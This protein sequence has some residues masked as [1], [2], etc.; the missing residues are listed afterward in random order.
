MTEPTIS[1]V[2]VSHERDDYLHL[3]A[4]SLLQQQTSGTYEFVLFRNGG[5]PVPE[6][7]VSLLSEGL[8]NWFRLFYSPLNLNYGAALIKAL[9]S[10]DAD[11]ILV[12][13]DDDLLL[14]NYLRVMRGLATEN[15]QATLLSVGAEVIDAQGNEQ[16]ITHSPP[17]FTSQLEAISDLMSSSVYWMPAS[18]FRRN[19]VDLS[20][21]PQTR[22]AID[23]WIWV[24]CWLDGLAEVSPEICVQYRRHSNQESHRYP[25]SV[26][27]ADA[28]EMLTR[29]IMSEKYRTFLTNLPTGDRVR[30]ADR[31]QSNG[32]LGGPDN[33]WGPAIAMTL[34]S[35]L[36]SLDCDSTAEALLFNAR[37]KA[38]AVPRLE[39]ALPR[40]GALPLA[41]IPAGWWSEVGIGATWESECSFAADWRRALNLP[42]GYDTIRV[43]LLV[44]C[45]CAGYGD[46]SH[47]LEFFRERSY[48]RKHPIY[49]LSGAV[50]SANIELFLDSL[51]PLADEYGSPLPQ[52]LFERQILTMIRRMKRSLIGRK[53]IEARRGLT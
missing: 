6:Q 3:F 33:G 11:Y 34:G 43:L 13:G 20:Q 46:G 16:G 10:V 37:A 45:S 1:V 23:W 32:A 26:F 7:T 4:K 19:S 8:G 48:R 22:T 27:H 14:P 36:A 44:R 28:L 41:Q 35:L 51:W 42:S 47:E 39:T 25:R 9:E 31:V 29:T 12:P 2:V 40:D 15:P 18:G 38:G 24:Q 30:F 49:R 17:Q 53:L 50:D 21:L 52:D 5:S